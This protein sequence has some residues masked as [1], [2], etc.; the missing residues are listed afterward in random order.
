VNIFS[1]VPYPYLGPTVLGHSIFKLNKI[2]G[3]NLKYI[4]A[5]WDILEFADMGTAVDRVYLV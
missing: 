3:F 5:A 4:G 2:I 1:K